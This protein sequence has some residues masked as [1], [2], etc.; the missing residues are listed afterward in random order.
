MAVTAA[1]LKTRRCGGRFK[2]PI[3]ASTT[4]YENALAFFNTS[5]Y[6]V[7]TVSLWVNELA[8]VVVK[9]VDNSAG[10]AG[11]LSAEVDSEGAFVFAGTGFSQASVGKPAYATD[12]FTVTA[13]ATAAGCYVGII[14]EYISSTSVLVRLNAN[15]SRQSARVAQAVA[16]VNDTTPTAAE[17]AAAFGAAASLGRGFIGT[18][19]DADGDTNHYI[20]SVSDASFFYL[21]MT[22][23]V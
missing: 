7:N 19:D 16:N 10:A 2:A 6:L 12:N 14:E 21:K 18:V 11:D 5:G 23:A 13:D 9:G 8:G 1:Q 20:V 15:R 4:L 22:K 3:A 17:L